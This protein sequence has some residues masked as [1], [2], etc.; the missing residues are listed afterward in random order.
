MDKTKPTMVSKN[1]ALCVSTM[2]GLSTKVGITTVSQRKK[3][4]E[5]ERWCDFCNRLKH[6]METYWKLHDQPTNWKRQKPEER[7]QGMRPLAKTQK[8]LELKRE[9]IL[10]YHS[11]LFLKGQGSLTMPILTSNSRGETLLE[12]VAL[13][14]VSTQGGKKI[15]KKL[16]DDLR[17]PTEKLIKLY[18]DN[19]EA[20]INITHNTLQHDRTKHVEVDRHFIKERL[21]SLF[22]KKKLFVHFVLDPVIV[23]DSSAG[24]SFAAR[25]GCLVIIENVERLDVGALVSIRGIGRVKIMEFVQADPY[26]KGIVIP[27]QD[28]IF[29]CESE[30]SS[31]VSEL[32]EALYSLN[33]LEIKLKTRFK[34]V[35]VPLGSKRTISTWLDA[36]CYKWHQS[37][38]PTPMW[39]FVWPH[40][41]VFVYLA[42]QSHGTQQECCVVCMGGVCDVP[43]RM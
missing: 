8:V 32:K 39:W 18:F 41:G 17:I 26:L 28:N 22:R 19:K 35:R 4:N 40:R 36:G 34:V 7:T 3:F 14:F 2:E 29:E 16:L 12:Q 9:G 42:S 23:G 24:S 33:S 6:A 15:K 25:Y 38:F 27:M 1:F 21:E 43:H 10:P 37:R 13:N 11:W 31:K 20:A 5:Q 30:I